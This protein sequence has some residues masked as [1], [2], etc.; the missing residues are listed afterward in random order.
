MKPKPAFY[1]L[2]SHVIPLPLQPSEA[3]TTWVDEDAP[4][5]VEADERE[6]ITLDAVKRESKARRAG[7]LRRHRPRPDLTNVPNPIIPPGYFR[8][9]RGLT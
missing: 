4:Y 9:R 1:V 7:G 6:P 5:L 3:G 8:F 2:G